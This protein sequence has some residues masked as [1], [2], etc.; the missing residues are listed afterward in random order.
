MRDL[1]S[2]Y[3]IDFRINIFINMELYKIREGLC[4]DVIS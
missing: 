4:T 1:K 2:K 3:A